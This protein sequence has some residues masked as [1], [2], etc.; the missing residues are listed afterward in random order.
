SPTYY[1]FDTFEEFQ[2][3]TGGSD[4]RIQTAGVQMNMVTK[5]GTND[6]SGSG[7]YLY[8]PGSTSAEATVPAEATPYL[9]LTNKVNYVRDYGGEVGGPVLRTA[10]GCGLRAAIRRSPRGSRWPRRVR[11]SSSRTT[12]SSATRTPRSTR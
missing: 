6:Y 12:P 9:S 7:R 1:D 3:T 8:V 2:I 5:R 10:S 11:H 4:P